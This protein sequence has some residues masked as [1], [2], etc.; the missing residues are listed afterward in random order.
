MANVIDS[1][2]VTLGLDSKGFAE[3]VKGSTEQLAG[4]TRRLAGMLI[5]VKG[6]E[7][8]VSYFKDL[9]QQLAE[10]GFESKNLGVAGTELKKLGEV[11][12]LFGGQVGDAA[13]SVQSLQADVFNLRFKGQMSESLQMLQRFG[14]AYLTASGHARNFRDIAKD[15]AKAID[16]QAKIAGLDKGERY[17][18]ALSFGFQGGIASAVAQGGKGLE[19]ALGKSELD[20]KA[21]TQKTIEGQ[22]ALEKQLIRQH[23]QLAAVNS[24]LLAQ[25][26]PAIAQLNKWMQDLINKTIPLLI[27]AINSVIEFF[28][29]PPP[30][31][32]L[33]QDVLKDLASTL[34]S[35]GTLLAAIAGLVGAL[36]SL[37]LTLAVGLGI[38]LGGII[39]KLFP[40]GGFLDKVNEKLLDAFGPG[41]DYNPNAKTPAEQAKLD[42]LRKGHI[43]RSGH[44]AP[45]TPT[46]PRPAGA[47]AQS[48]GQ[49]HGSGTSVQID[50]MTIHTQA[51]DADG[52]AH[53]FKGALERKLAVSQSD[54][55]QQ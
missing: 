40:S 22:V 11:A 31:L 33:I 41:S 1:L 38:L 13:A 45:P 49:G 34:G 15:A 32:Q 14:V 29:N 39:D 10:I 19:D 26:T 4:F 37:P 27:K 7:D 36:I 17:Q 5:A 23:E 44:P 42:A 43:D 52:V 47:A 55:G 12:E 18:L 3:G 2:V 25:V 6:I 46:A 50:N 21:L 30:W 24:T 16:K 48:A 54:A 8:V 28:K 35:G 53:D 9:H 20:Q 51:T